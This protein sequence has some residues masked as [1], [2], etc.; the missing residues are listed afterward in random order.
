MGNFNNNNQNTDQFADFKSAEKHKTKLIIKNQMLNDQKLDLENQIVELFNKYE[1]SA[2]QKK[3][4]GIGG[5]RKLYRLTNK[6]DNINHKIQKNNQD[7]ELINQ[8]EFIEETTFQKIKKTIVCKKKKTK[9]ISNYEGQL[10]TIIL[11]NNLAK[12]EAKLARYN[13][14]YI[15]L[16]NKVNENEVK[17]IKDPAI[18]EKK[19]VKLKTRL[20]KTTNDKKTRLLENKLKLLEK[21]Q[22]DIKFKIFHNFKKNY[23]IRKVFKISKKIDRLKAKIQQIRVGLVRIESQTFEKLNSFQ[24]LRKMFSNMSYKQQKVVFGILF[25]LPWFVGFCIFFASPLFTTIWWSLNNMSLLEGGGFSFQFVGL[26]NYKELFSN[27]TLGGITIPEILTS[28]LI[29]IL[30]DLPTIIIFSLFIAVLL[31]TK[32]KGHQ[33]VKAIFFIPVVY[34]MS[35]INNTLTGTFGQVL[36]S[37]VS[38]GFILSQQFSEFL[39]KIGIGNNLVVFLTSAVDRIFTIVNMSGIQILIFIAALQSIP[40]HLYEAAKVEGASKY[41]MFWKI[42]I[43]MVSPMI[44]T[45]IVYTV[46]NS[47]ATSDIMVFMTVNSQGTTMATNQPG[48]YSAISIIYFLANTLIILFVFTLLKKVV[49][50]YDE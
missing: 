13:E 19:Q 40:A 5:I 25:I 3:I 50:Y 31:K 35:V 29:D 44:L 41:E 7:I 47:F 16:G 39:M 28:S 45:T 30:I 36:N 34:N 37:D 9:Y 43:P 17:T 10:I 1:V 12:L 48:L 14:R 26:G 24:R 20:L 18:L 33:L 23:L 38:E 42:T 15:E 22:I 2:K 11:N 32:F 27:K 46:V 21:N 6:L 8:N 4:K 49:F